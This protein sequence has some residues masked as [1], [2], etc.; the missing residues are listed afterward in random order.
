MRAVVFGRAG[1]LGSF[2]ADA[3]TAAGHET[4]I[5][6]KIPN[7]ASRFLAMLTAS[8]SSIS[9]NRTRAKDKAP[10]SRQAAG[11]SRKPNSAD[12]RQDVK[13]VKPNKLSSGPSELWLVWGLGLLILIFYSNSFSAGL[14]F[15]SESIVKMDPRLRGVSL[16]NARDIFAR[17]YWWPTDE[18]VLYRPLT[19]LSYLFNYTI[20]GNGENPGGYHVVNFVLHWANSWLVF[21]IA[22]RLAGR[23][24]LA[25]VTASL[26]A[27][28]P[29]NTE[30]VTNVVGRADLL[31]AFCVLLGG[32]SYL[33]AQLSGARRA[34]WLAITGVAACLGVTAKENAVMIAGFVILDD[35]LWRW[36]VLPNGNRL[37]RLKALFQKSWAGYLAL[38]PGILLIWLIRRWVAST[39]L[40]FE[41]FFLDNPL[42]GAAPFQRFITALGI[43]G[44]YLQL[45]VF[46]QKLSADYSFNQIPLFGTGHSE[47]DVIAWISL[48][49]IGVLLLAAIYL[50]ARQKLFSWG[51]LFFFLMLLPTSNLLFT[52]GSIM[53]ERFLYLPSIGFCAASAAVL[54]EVSNRLRLRWTL[55]IIVISALG[56]RTFVR[57]ADWR[58]DLT[59]WTSSVAAAPGSY[60]AH[61][62]YGEAILADAERKNA[63][64][65]EQVID[66][67]LKQH[68]IARSILDTNPPLPLK[69]ENI[70]SYLHI[71]KDYRLKGQLADNAGRRDEGIKFYRKSLEALGKAQELDRF[72]NQLSRDYRLRRGIPAGEIPDIGNFFVYESL[73]LTYGR[74][75]EWEKCEAPARYLQHI[76]P[77]Q[78]SGYQL[79]GAA[80]FNLG[81]Y[82][83]AAEQFLAGLLVNP[84]NSD[85]L[86][87]LRTTYENLGIEPNPVLERGTTLSLRSEAPYVRDQLTRSAEMVLRLFKESGKSEEAQELQNRVLKEYSLRPEV[88]PR[89][90]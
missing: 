19:T 35:F 71:A 60:K 85:W 23:L 4:I 15:D 57:N 27:V 88:S 26:F 32:W 39:A 31:A 34:R 9:S 30:A 66:A 80:D 14:L 51:M 11:K 10:R 58:D 18:S 65:S 37:E 5:D 50:R 25:A 1:F 41:E 36:P 33:E 49:L 6:E 24:D 13:E 44:R 42:I 83:D 72:K 7:R 53:A 48:L 55:P 76:A 2:M 81:R 63:I 46:P 8:F 59:L 22:R 40:V 28:H 87:S 43:I 70:T 56:V 84:A 21:L 16:A 77:E 61:M 89:K 20:L 82:H 45:L 47:T 17:N 3:L 67:A 78:P 86:T 38:I 62:L 64:P 75:A 68:E 69:W 74:L 73:C 52:I 12:G 54:C 90:S 79:L 29:V